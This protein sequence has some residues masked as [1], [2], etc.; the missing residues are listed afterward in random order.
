MQFVNLRRRAAVHLFLPGY[1]P[2]EAFPVCAH[3]LI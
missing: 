3:L 2:D 1:R